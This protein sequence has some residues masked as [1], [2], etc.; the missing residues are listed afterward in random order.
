MVDLKIANTQ[1]VLN[2]CTFLEKHLYFEETFRVYE[3]ALN[4]LTWP[5]I[6]EVWLIYLTNFVERYKS[7]KIERARDLFEQVIATCP[8]DK[9]KVFYYLYADLEE[10]YGL[11][12]NC[13]RILDRACSDISKDEKPEIFSVL[14]AKTSNF[15]GITKTRA[16]F[17]VNYFFN[18]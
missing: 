12:N 10:N 2:Y 3:Q 13:I 17:S 14:I 16:V 11:L 1:T 18:F 7:E 5:Y 8:K 4:F 15:F 9:I 6:Y